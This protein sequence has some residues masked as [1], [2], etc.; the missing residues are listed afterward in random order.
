MNYESE[1][2]SYSHRIPY[3]SLI[4]FVTETRRS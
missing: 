4:D 1:W 3:S 2:V